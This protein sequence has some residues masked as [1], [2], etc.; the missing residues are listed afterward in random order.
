M[1]ENKTVFSYILSNST[2][3][4]YRGIPVRYGSYSRDAIDVS[5]IAYLGTNSGFPTSCSA[6]GVCDTNGSKYLI[7]GWPV[8]E[9]EAD[10]LNFIGADDKQYYLHN[11]FI[12]TGVAIPSYNSIKVNFRCKAWSVSQGSYAPQIHH[13]TWEWYSGDII[14]NRL[15]NIYNITGVEY[16]VEYR[17]RY[18]KAPNTYATVSVYA[19]KNS[20]GWAE[21]ASVADATTSG[22]VPNSSVAY[23]NFYPTLQRNV[24]G[25]WRDVGVFTLANYSSY[26]SVTSG[27]INISS[28]NSTPTYYYGATTGENG[29]WPHITSYDN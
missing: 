5:A 7:S 1:I 2:L 27:T 16:R 14:E 12:N 19:T 24:N 17:I 26:N 13:L 29:I 4:E 3:L 10:R 6:L 20:S 23:W 15:E 9:S 8:S 25:T 28:W 21:W 11:R 22:T 18:L